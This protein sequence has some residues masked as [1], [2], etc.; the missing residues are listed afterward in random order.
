MR[1]ALI[2]P[3]SPVKLPDGR[4]IPRKG[5]NVHRLRWTDHHPSSSNGAGVLIDSGGKIYDA[6]TFA[7]DRDL[8][9]AWLDAEDME[10]V[11]RALGGVAPQKQGA[12]T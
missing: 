6:T 5:H 3:L 4:V 11:K 1:V 12:T 9:G 8:L 10:R 7:R 2:I